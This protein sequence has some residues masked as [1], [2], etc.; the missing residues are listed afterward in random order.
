VDALAEL[1][2]LAG[3]DAVIDRARGCVS[4]GDAVLAIHLAEGVLAASPDHAGARGVMV[5][6]H[7]WLLD[8]GGSDNLWENGWLREQIVRNGGE[9]R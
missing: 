2:A 5:D 1:V 3:P 6:A 9:P 4:G 7:Q 8:A